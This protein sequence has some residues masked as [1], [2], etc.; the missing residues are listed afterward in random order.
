[1]CVCFR[2]VSLPQLPEENTALEVDYCAK[3]TIKWYA[4]LVITIAT[5][6][7]IE[8]AKFT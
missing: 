3:T 7:W 1:M 4:C 2:R 5:T 6:V 8:K